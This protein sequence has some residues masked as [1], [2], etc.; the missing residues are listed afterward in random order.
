MKT[1]ETQSVTGY[2]AFDNNMKCMN[3]FQYEVGKIYTMNENEVVLC[4]SGFHFCMIPIDVFE[5]YYNHSKFAV[6][7]ATGKIIH[8]R[9]KSVCSQITIEKL[10]T[11]DELYKLTNGKFVRN[12][13]DIEHYQNGR[14]HRK[15]GPAIEHANGNKEWYINGKRRCKN[16]GHAVENTDGY[17]LW[18]ENGNWYDVDGFP[19]KRNNGMGL[20]QLVF[21]GLGKL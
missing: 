18:F 13:G 21:H 12:N 6:I 8:D 3:N 7:K 17:K 15:N 10:I 19:I 14:L 16:D 4:Q 11:L 1:T 9:N 2:K 5:Y 20:M